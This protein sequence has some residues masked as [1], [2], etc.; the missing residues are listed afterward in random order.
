RGHPAGPGAA[1]LTHPGLAH[2]PAGRRRS[3]HPRGAH[4]VGDRGGRRPDRPR[5]RRPGGVS[6]ARSGYH[7][8]I[9]RPTTQRRPDMGM[10]DKIENKMDE[11]KGS[12]KENYGKATDNESLEAEGKSDQSKAKVSEAG[13]K[14]KDAAGDVKDAFKS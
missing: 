13:E 6:R 5:S 10:G 2:H 1:L 9:T 12:A 14:V 8:D 7:L 4:R 3:E 11:A